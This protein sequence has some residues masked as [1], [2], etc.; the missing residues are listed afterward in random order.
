[1]WNRSESNMFVCHCI[2]VDNNLCVYQH[3]CNSSFR[4]NVDCAHGLQRREHR[5][6]RPLTCH[7]D[8]YADSPSVRR[9]RAT[10]RDWAD[11][12]IDVD[13]DVDMNVRDLSMSAGSRTRRLPRAVS[14]IAALLRRRE[15]Q[16][17]FYPPTD[18]AMN[19]FVHTIGVTKLVFQWD[20]NPTGSR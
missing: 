16:V 10:P 8:W 9:R 11:G 4:T 1:M 17:L 15:T 18:A 6:E 20:M 7:A 2:Q 13:M 5:Y 12:N 14:D 19:G 3:V